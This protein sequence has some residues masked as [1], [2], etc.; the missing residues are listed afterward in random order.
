MVNWARI[1]FGSSVCVHMYVCTCVCVRVCMCICVCVCEC[2]CVCVCGRLQDGDCEEA[3]QN[4]LLESM[5]PT[6]P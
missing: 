6:V 2:V 1:I 5:H 3:E 4:N